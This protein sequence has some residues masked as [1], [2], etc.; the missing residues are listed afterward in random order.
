VTDLSG[1]IVHTSD[2]A[3]VRWTVEQ[4]RFLLRAEDTGGL[5]SLIEFTTE[6][7]GGPPLHIHASEDEAFYVLEGEYQ[8]RVGDDTVTA[9]AGTVAYGPRGLVHGFRNTGTS[10]ARML[11]IA[12]PG[13]AEKMFEGLAAILAGTTPIDRRA[14]ADLVESFGVTYLQES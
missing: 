11:C 9:G 2:V 5:F 3:P 13:G 14:I 12:T 1:R 8:I 7:G 4:G 10:T 6:P